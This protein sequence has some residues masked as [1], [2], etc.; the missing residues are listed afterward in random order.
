MSVKGPPRLSTFALICLSDTV[1]CVFALQNLKTSSRTLMSTLDRLPRET[2]CREGTDENPEKDLMARLLKMIMKQY[3]EYYKVQT[4]LL[5]VT[6]LTTRS[7]FIVQGLQSNPDMKHVHELEVYDLTPCTLKPTSSEASPDSL[8]SQ[9]EASPPFTSRIWVR[10]LQADPFALEAVFKAWLHPARRP[11]LKLVFSEETT[12]HCD[13]RELVLRHQGDTGSRRFDGEGIPY[14]NLH[15]KKLLSNR[16][17]CDALLPGEAWL[18][19]P[20]A[21]G[22]SQGENEENP[23]LF[24]A[25]SSSLA[26]KEHLLLVEQ[27]SSERFVVIPSPS[28][29]IIRSVARREY[30]LPMPFGAMTAVEVPTDVAT[31]VDELLEDLPLLT[32]VYN[33]ILESPGVLYQRLVHELRQ[34]TGCF[35][36]GRVGSSAGTKFKPPGGA[37]PKAVSGRR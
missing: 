7:S 1:E 34:S 29:L 32:D 9:T 24:A 8:T 6:V 5:D 25:L 28:S 22:V 11:Q 33:P 17:I 18:L 10:R 4:P 36:S 27:D 23:L 16:S 35:A 26:R 14:G 21:G 31:R 20:A 12:I 15:V 19:L 37:K 30:I 3:R 13:I 2:Q